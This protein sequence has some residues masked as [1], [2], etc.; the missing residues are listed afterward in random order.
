MMANTRF[1]R[2]SRFRPTNSSHKE[3]PASGVL[4]FLF[5]AKSE[6]YFTPSSSTSKIKVALGG[7]T[8]PAPRDP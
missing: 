3:T 5:C 8:P 7:I 4:A 1:R 2:R 6:F